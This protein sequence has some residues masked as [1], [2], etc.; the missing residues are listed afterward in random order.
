MKS[1]GSFRG[2]SNRPLSNGISGTYEGMPELKECGYYD[3]QQ[4]QMIVHQLLVSLAAASVEKASADPFKQ[5]TSFV[6]DLKVEMLEYLHQQV[7]SY[8]TGSGNLSTSSRF[9]TPVKLVGDA[10][11]GFLRS[12][13]SLFRRVSSK[14]LSGDVNDKKIEEFVQELERTG[15][16]LAGK[17][18]VVA[19]SL[20]KRAD[21][22]RMFHCDMRFDKSQEFVEHK[23]KC[24]LRPIMCTNEGC[25]EVLSAIHHD[26]HDG[27]CSFKLLPCKQ[28]C[29]STVLRKDME[30]HC[31][32]TCPNKVVPCPFN[33]V[34]CD[35]ML[36]QGSLVQ[37]YTDF[38]ASHLLYVLQSLHKQ[39]TTTGIQAQ[40]IHLLEKTLSIS[41]R[42]EAVDVGSI[43]L[44]VKEHESR[45]KSL[46]QEV[47][48]LRQELKA[49][50]VSVEVLQLRREIR[51]LQ[52]Q[53]E[54]LSH[55]S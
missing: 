5:P 15:S 45:I 6:E 7:E 34:G 18:E 31:S 38:I 46:E 22:S 14:L 48:K 12:K 8:A 52:K 54:N 55:G 9:Q 20:L 23:A 16:W 36:P 26:E 49:T 17:R 42:S 35:A 37:H 50:D 1:V 11:Q 39:E 30:F 33:E 43:S 28:S 4:I 24:P 2:G 25:V 44:T 47:S 13:R 27:T 40:R 10:L 21:R 29:G 19:K 32:T 53:V 41:Q 51:N 3:V